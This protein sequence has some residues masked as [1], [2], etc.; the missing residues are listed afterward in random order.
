MCIRS[1]TL[2]FYT[3]NLP[4]GGSGGAGVGAGAGAGGASRAV[5][6]LVLEAPPI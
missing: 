6:F 3:F 2:K 1:K 4:V 5:F